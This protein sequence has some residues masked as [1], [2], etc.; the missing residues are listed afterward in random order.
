MTMRSIAA[1]MLCLPLF[2]IAARQPLKRVTDIAL[3]GSASRFDYASI[4]PDTHR[5]FVAHLGEGKVAVVDID[6]GKSIGEIPGIGKVHGVL[7]VPGLGLVFAS[8]TA[9]NE[10]VAIDSRTMRIVARIPGGSYPDGMAY[11]PQ[12]KRLYVSDEHGSTETVID[13][14]G[15]RRIATIELGSEVGNSQFD[16]TSGHVFVN[17]QSVDRLVEIDPKTDSI[18]GRYALPGC[19]APHGLLIDSRD[20][21][22]FAACEGNDR[23]VEIALGSMRVLDSFPVGEGPDVLAFDPALKQLYVAAEK[24]KVSIFRIAGRKMRK[25]GEIFVGEN[26][27]VVV[28]DRETHLVYFPLMNVNDFPVLRVMEPSPEK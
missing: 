2:A 12:L 7:A 5:L 18:A 3:P 20:R 25:T 13:A 4:D 9:T 11:V 22:A 6:R 24:G 17:A 27:H 21:L 8:A 23:L 14:A 1:L 10:V 19:K 28:V 15:K 16:P 26:A